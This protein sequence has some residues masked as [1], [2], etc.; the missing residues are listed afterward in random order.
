MS[1]V[2]HPKASVNDKKEENAKSS[3]SFIDCSIVCHMGHYCKSVGQVY[4]L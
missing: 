3:F 1:F 2:V 4:A